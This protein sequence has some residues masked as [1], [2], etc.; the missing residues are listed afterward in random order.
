VTL[1]LLFNKTD[2]RVLVLAP[3][4]ILANLSEP[5]KGWVDTILVGYLPDPN[6]ISAVGLGTLI[7]TFLFWA[8]GFLRLGTVGFA[9]QAAGR[10][11][12]FG[13][14]AVLW[15]GLALAAAISL[16]LV[17]LQGP[18][19]WGALAFFDAGAAVDAPT[20]VY[21]DWRIW[22][23]PS[24]LGF[25]CLQGWLLGLHDI[26]AVAILT[27]GQHFLNALLS[28]FLVLVFDLGI[29]GVAAG[30]LI[31]EW[32]IF[33]IAAWVTWRHYRRRG[34]RFAPAML[35]GGAEM[36]AF[37]ASNFDLFLRIV[38]MML[39][40]ALFSRESA[41]LG[42][43]MLAVNTLLLQLLNLTA[44]AM[45]GF[46]DVAEPLVGSAAGRRDRAA[47]TDAVR[48]CLKIGALFGLLLILFTWLLGPLVLDLFTQHQDLVAEALLFLPWLIVGPV[49]FLVSFVM[50]GV[51]V[52]ATRTAAMRNAMLASLLLFLALSWLLVPLM[53]NHGL[54]LAFILWYGS[55]GLALALLLPRELTKMAAAPPPPRSPAPIEP[56]SPPR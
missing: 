14:A 52:G 21:F 35:K 41:A 55:R 43:R 56:G 20:Q 54:W 26:R 39:A 42:E 9:A 2:R 23:A 19:A 30:T 49:V 5:A 16:L 28:A 10:G 47:L 33:F 7:F 51:F 1:P 46:K 6:L 31:A 4:L 15:R 38:A 3:P 44:A 45:D 17:L 27:I 11:D 50:D 48:S 18:I 29:V 32:L 22:A 34:L 36:L 8:F 25:Y 13:L 12:A 40:F 37:L 24:A 53:G